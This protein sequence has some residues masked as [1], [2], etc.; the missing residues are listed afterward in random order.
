MTDAHEGRV[1]LPDPVIDVAGL[2]KHFGAFRV[3]DGLDLTVRPGEVAGFLGPNGA[4]KSTTIRVLLGLYR[5]DGGTVRVF[6]ADPHA[7]AV[8]IHARLAYVPGDVNLWPQLTGGQC[9]DLLLSLRG[10]RAESASRRAELIDRFDLDPT[11]KASTYS[12]G[13]RQKVALIA[14]LAADTELLI[15]D[16]PTS[17]LDPLMTHQFTECIRECAAQ[18]S[19]VLMSS[20]ILA[21]VEQLCDTVTIIRDGR[22]VQSGS[23]REL[24]HLRR[25]RV[26]AT[27]AGDSA[28][29]ASVTGV[30]DFERRAD[31][32]VTFTVDD[33]GLASVTRELADRD[34]R[35]LAV[36]PPSLEEL[37][38][39]AYGEHLEV[40]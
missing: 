4:G 18:G 24:R 26:T 33:T 6:G 3:L 27:V 10:I 40:R 29:L 1:G 21:E 17:G 11:K 30:H 36:T 31:G 34:V 15:L 25:S 2:T 7:D 23:L 39:H 37:F 9:I 13:N 28:D 35:T 12:K 14:A 8:A 22:T 19:A 20:H 32:E 16:E 5:Y 38:L